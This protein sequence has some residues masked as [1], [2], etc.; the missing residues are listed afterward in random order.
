MTNF[1]DMDMGENKNGAV[2]RPAILTWYFNQGSI[3]SYPEGT[4]I[5]IPKNSEKVNRLGQKM[6]KILKLIIRIVIYVAI[7][8][9]VLYL[10][11][12]FKRVF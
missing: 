1:P 6:L 4:T 3:K 11:S 8:L 9:A 2:P 10:I 12:T 5:I 7:I